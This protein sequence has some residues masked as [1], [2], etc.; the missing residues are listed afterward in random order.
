MLPRFLVPD[1][2]PSRS[3]ATLPADEAHHLAKVLRLK[4][5]DELTVFDGRG[6]EYRARVAAVARRAVSVKLLHVVDAPPAA[7][8]A[9]VLVQAV[10]KGEAMDEV[11]RDGTMVGVR[12][13]QPVLSERVTV[14][15]S[16]VG[17]SVER[18]RR[19]AL[20][21]AKQCGRSALPEIGDP[22]PFGTW[23][24]AAPRGDAF[25]LV[26]PAVARSTPVSVR[27]LARGPIPRTAS[28]IVGPEGGWTS[29][30]ID[31]A[32]AAGCTAL[33]LGRMTLRAD[34]VPLAAAAAL[35]AVWEEL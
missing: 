24:D 32:L 27:T 26:E 5:G 19:I 14:K 11:V 13:I 21:S 25:L 9:L 29:A 12:A 7:A 10:L 8:V 30:E 15:A 6:L 4:V 33:S 1:L 22:M 2:D 35:L 23:V 20:A 28:L 34:A 17:R 3:D 18:W 16:V 31:L